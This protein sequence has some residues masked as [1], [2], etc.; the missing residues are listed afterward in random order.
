MTSATL[1]R[2][3]KL[4]RHDVRSTLPAALTAVM[5]N[6]MLD[7][8][9]QD[10]LLPEFLF[11]ALGGNEPWSGGMGDTVTKTRRGLL[12]PAVTPITGSDPSA[13]T[14]GIEQWSVTMD[15]YGNAVDTNLLQSSMT[16]AS[17]YLEDVQA[18]A[19]NAGQSLNQIARNKLY[20]AYAGGRT[21]ATAA[22]TTDTSIAVASVDGFTSV[23]VNGVPTAVSAS[24][25]LTVTIAGVANTVTGTSVATGAGTLTLGTTR[26][27][28]AGDTVVAAN[29]PVSYRPNARGSAYDIISTD[30]ATFSTFRSAVTRLR[31][32]NVPTVGGY[33][34][35]HIPPDTEAQLFAD[36][37][38][39]QAL[40]G[41]VDSPVYTNLSIG[42]FGGIDWVR[43][44]ECPTVLST[45]GVT[46]QRPLVLGDGAVTNDPFS[47]MGNLTAGVEGEPSAIR[48]IGPADGVQ[49]ALITREPQDRLQQNVSTAWSWVGDFGVPSD[50]TA[51]GSDAARY[52]RGVVIEHAS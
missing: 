34:V 50:V 42:R 5:Q 46:V 19:T 48:M 38:F 23:M 32:M 2:W 29:A 45:T 24:N 37:D 10:A 16:L 26:I 9:F 22:A 47:E 12:A 40:Q 52:K 8:V 3:F 33:Y 14:Y 6:G 1:R 20:K 15:Q 39:K 21:W 31:K 36:A 35:A 41:R 13:A 18:L 30:L 7:R 11:A 51:A 43:N 28:V 49:V 44:N 4:D 25:P 17:K 27:D